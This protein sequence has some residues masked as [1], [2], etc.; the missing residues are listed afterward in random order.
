MAIFVYLIVQKSIS[1]AMDA[2]VMNAVTL[3]IFTA[4][5]KKP[6]FRMSARNGD[7]PKQSIIPIVF[8]N[9]GAQH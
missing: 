9:S 3:G 7:I 5:H 8:K 4:D 2:V 1:L 6:S